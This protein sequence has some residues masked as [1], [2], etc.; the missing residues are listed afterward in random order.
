MWRRRSSDVR[1]SGSGM[2]MVRR[3]DRNAILVLSF[4]RDAGGGGH[5]SPAWCRRPRSTGVL[6]VRAVSGGD[7]LQLVHAAAVHRAGGDRRRVIA[8]PQVATYLLRAA[9]DV[10][11]DRG[12]CHVRV[13]GLQRPGDFGGATVVQED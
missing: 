3:W 10:E 12:R 13:G 4:G 6:V 9:P 7:R 8:G 11:A 2:V 5:A 1:K